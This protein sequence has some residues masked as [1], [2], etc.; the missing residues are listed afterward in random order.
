M[1]VNRSELP[2]TLKRSPAK[3]Q[4]TFMKALRGAHRDGRSS[5]DEGELAAALARRR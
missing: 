5:M 1:P 3:A 2:D 4:R